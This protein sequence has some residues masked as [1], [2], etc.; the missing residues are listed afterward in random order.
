MIK[1]FCVFVVAPIYHP[2]QCP[3]VKLITGGMHTF[4]S[5]QLTGLVCP[6]MWLLLLVPSKNPSSP[7]YPNEMAITPSTPPPPPDSHTSPAPLIF[8]PFMHT[9]H[10]HIA[11]RMMKQDTK[12]KKKIHFQLTTILIVTTK[13]ANASN[14]KIKTEAGNTGTQKSSHIHCNC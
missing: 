8:V 9:P 1:S 6:R 5:S 13:S 11:L 12:Q 3:T 14:I 7:D 4:Q 2:T 10:S